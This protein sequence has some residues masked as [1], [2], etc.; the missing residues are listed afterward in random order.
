MGPC[1]DQNHKTTITRTHLIPTDSISDETMSKTAGTMNISIS[2]HYLHHK[3]AWGLPAQ[4]KLQ[5]VNARAT[6][7][8]SQHSLSEKNLPPEAGLL[9]VPK[10]PE[11]PPLLDIYD[12]VIYVE[13][14]G[15]IA[16]VRDIPWLPRPFDIQTPGWLVNL[17]M[18]YGATTRDMV[19][20][21]DPCCEP[22]KSRT[23]LANRLTKR[24]A[25]WR[26]ILGGFCADYRLLKNGKPCGMAQSVIGGIQ[27][28]RDALSDEQLCYV[29]FLERCFDVHQLT[30]EVGCHLGNRHR[31]TYYES[32]R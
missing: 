3:D 29:S 5:E 9:F 14:G 13:R 22:L 28:R 19:D 17:Y 11:F 2:Y 1:F 27:G 25:D 15:Q 12:Q 31:K 20:R 23:Q 7:I 30:C 16:A 32:T 6:E 10:P 21:I 26:K 4:W 18:I 8:L 24:S